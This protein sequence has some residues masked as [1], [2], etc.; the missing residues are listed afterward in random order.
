MTVKEKRKKI[1]T[2]IYGTAS[3]FDKSGRNTKK[4][5]E[6]FGK[7]S[8]EQF[9]KWA[10]KFFKDDEENFYFEVLPYK[11]EPILKDIQEAANYLGIELEEYIY[12][13]SGDDK[14]NPVRSA[15]KVPTGWIMTKRLQQ[16]LMK[17]NSYGWDISVRNN[18]TNQLTGDSRVARI[19]DAETFNLGVWNADLAVK[20]FFSARGDDDVAKMEMYKEIATQGY[21]QLQ[22]YTD[23]LENK[24]TL[25]TVDVY[26]M[27]AG[28]MTD[29]VTEGLELTR[30]VEEKKRR[31]SSNEKL[32][33][34]TS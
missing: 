25:N 24:T 7:M 12:Y 4:F 34:R 10:N 22:D 29:L 23:E 1:E 28:L 14:D 21:T 15:Y 26:F 32:N 30:T 18:K 6:F 16:M 19:S 3:R 9:T 8:D 27:G 17:K 11:N 2:L 20:E 31:K 13:R 33:D 5:K